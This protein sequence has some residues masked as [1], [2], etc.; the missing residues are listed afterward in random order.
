LQALIG[1]VPSPPQEISLT[2]SVVPY[3][4]LLWAGV[5]FMC[6]GISLNVIGDS[7]ILGIKGKDIFL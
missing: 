4:Y 3:V 2:V 1:G 7:Q 6:V 5:I